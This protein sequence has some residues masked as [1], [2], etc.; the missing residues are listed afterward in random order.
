LNLNIGQCELE[1]HTQGSD[2]VYSGEYYITNGEF[3]EVS[4]ASV[5]EHRDLGTFYRKTFKLDCNLGSGMFFVEY[6]STYIVHRYISLQWVLPKAFNLK[7][8]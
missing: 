8:A 1:V 5:K 6:C 4:I 3:P 2:F 7:V